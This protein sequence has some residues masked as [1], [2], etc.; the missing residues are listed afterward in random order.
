MQDFEKYLNNFPIIPVIASKIM[1]IAEDNLDI[2]FKDLEEMIR[3]DPMLTAKILKIANSA[4]YARQNKILNL[5]MAISL[6]GFKTIKSLVILLTASKFSKE[7]KNRKILNSFWKH[8]IAT[9]FIAKNILLRRKDHRNEEIVFIAGLLHDIG[10]VALFQ[11]Y[12]NDYSRF[13]TDQNTLA[14]VEEL[15][16]SLFGTDHRELGGF[17]LDK[18]NFPDV[19]SDVAREHGS[20]NVSSIHKSIVYTVSFADLVTEKIGFGQGCEVDDNLF[21]ELAGYLNISADDIVY[22]QN[23]FFSGLENDDLFL[24]CQDL[25]L[26]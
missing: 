6:L 16:K 18:W 14:S 17:I 10:Q 4:L 3:I 1:S 9:A 8:S 5:Q 22:Y 7:L 20:I 2:S 15:E 21:L 11:R 19:Y 13:F 25:F 12:P 23:D 26:T 24:E